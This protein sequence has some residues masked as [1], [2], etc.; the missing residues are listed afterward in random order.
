MIISLVNQ[1]ITRRSHIACHAAA[2]GWQLRRSKIEFDPR[3]ETFINDDQ[4]NEMISRLQRKPW[5]PLMNK[6]PNAT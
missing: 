5:T 2:I 1:D 3:V 6:L 4:A